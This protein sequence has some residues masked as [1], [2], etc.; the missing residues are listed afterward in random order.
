M[1]LSP[2]AKELLGTMLEDQLRQ[3]VE[4]GRG[5]EPMPAAWT[6]LHNAIWMDR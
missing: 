1:K 5:D 6:E 4:A 3:Q 2:E